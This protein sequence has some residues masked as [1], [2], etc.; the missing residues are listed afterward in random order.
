MLKRVENSALRLFQ[1][2]LNYVLIRDVFTI[3]YVKLRRNHAEFIEVKI[4]KCEHMK[5]NT[6]TRFKIL[7]A[8]QLFKVNEP[9]YK[10]CGVTPHFPKTKK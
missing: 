9:R 8:E 2:C 1:S 4:I 7:A 6:L 5:K 3:D 10:R